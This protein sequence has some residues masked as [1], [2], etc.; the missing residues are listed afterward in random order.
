MKAS[1]FLRTCLSITLF[2]LSS[3][4][5][6]KDTS[7]AIAF[8]AT[9]STTNELIDPPPMLKQKITGVGSSNEFNITKVTAISTQNTS[10]PPPFSLSGTGSWFAADGDIFYSDFAGK[11][12]PNP[13]GTITVT[14]TH[15]IT[16]GTG[17]FLHASGTIDG[18][19]IHDPK[20]GADSLTMTGTIKL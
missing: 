4:S 8:A 20:K 10:T 18:K 11:A 17:K 9:Y 14:M 19:T 1:L 7:A 3:F 6:K 15:K 5:C 13:D 2:G 16:G 12:T